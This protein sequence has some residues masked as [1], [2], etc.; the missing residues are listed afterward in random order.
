[1]TWRESLRIYPYHFASVLSIL[2]CFWLFYKYVRQMNKGIKS[3][4]VVILAASDMIFSANHVLEDY[5]KEYTIFERKIFYFFQTFS[6]CFSIFWASAI[7]YIVYKNL[8]DRYINLKELFIKVLL[9]TLALVL[10]WTI[11]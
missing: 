1:M 8:A 6:I 5:W 3:L 4:L 2:A 7:A 10:T 11:L 9:V